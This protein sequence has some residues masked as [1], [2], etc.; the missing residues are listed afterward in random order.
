MWTQGGKQ[1]V[2]VVMND[3][4][5]GQGSGSKGSRVYW[6][7]VFGVGWQTKCEGKGLVIVII[8]LNSFHSVL[9]MYHV[10]QW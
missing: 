6:R 3:R 8:S 7:C 2:K 1:S 5:D 10:G 9:S 4:G